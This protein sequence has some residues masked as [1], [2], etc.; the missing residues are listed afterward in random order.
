MITL[1]HAVDNVAPALSVAA[2]M[3]CAATAL[4]QSV[5]PRVN[6]PRSSH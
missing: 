4:A 1:K 3:L 2:M 5:T 6:L